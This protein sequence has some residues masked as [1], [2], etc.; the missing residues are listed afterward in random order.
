MR[1]FSCLFT[2]TNSKDEMMHLSSI[3]L[4]LLGF[5]PKYM[6]VFVSENE[7]LDDVEFNEI[8]L[9]EL[10]SKGASGILLKNQ[11]YDETNTTLWFRISIDEQYYNV[12]SFQWSNSSLDFLI[13]NLL[14]EKFYNSR[15]FISGYCYDQNDN[16][17]QSTEDI[18]YYKSQLGS[19]IVKIKKNQFNDD[20][21]DIS[22]NWGRSE[23][24][25]GI[26]FMAA[27]IM[28]FG[29]P[30]FDVISKQNLL[31]Y[32]YAKSMTEVVCVKHFDL[33]DLPSDKVNRSKQ[34]EFWQFFDLK[35]IILKYKKSHSIDLDNWVKE[36]VLLKKKKRK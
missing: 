16:F 4:K 30:F 11:L 6:N 9:F 5:E 24:V 13:N 17:L 32:K 36:Q 7:I 25:C 27:P 19:S 1:K 26:E 31:N 2:Y 21:I 10:L 12:F 23:R 8:L 15:N 29:L 28:W 18:A 3:A 22:E 20:V 14:F 34:K 33:K 35:N